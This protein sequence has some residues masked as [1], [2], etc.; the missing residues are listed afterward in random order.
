[1]IPTH[2]QIVA[3]TAPDL[4]H[5]VDGSAPHLT[6]EAQVWGDGK[7]AFAANQPED[8]NP[9]PEGHALWH[10][11]RRGWLGAARCA[12]YRLTGE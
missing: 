6:V 2:A 9:F 10:E 12:A 5:L 4:A 7:A 1:M 11:W 3:A 8:A